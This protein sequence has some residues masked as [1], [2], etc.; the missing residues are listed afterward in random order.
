MAFDYDYGYGL[1]GCV[2]FKKSAGWEKLKW[3]GPR[4]RRRNFPLKF[5]VW[6]KNC[7]RHVRTVKLK[8]REGPW[9][10][11]LSQEDIADA[12]DDQDLQVG[13]L[14]E[15]LNDAPLLQKVTVH[16]KMPVR[17]NKQT[18]QNHIA[19][20]REIKFG[21][22]LLGLL[23]SL[24]KGEIEFKFEVY[25]FAM[26]QAPCFVSSFITKVVGSLARL[27]PCYCSGTISVVVIPIANQ[28][29]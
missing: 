22:R 7:L 12:Y 21:K 10:S 5:S 14:V 3:Y 15:H 29:D 26:P 25:D 16:V 19:T 8:I 13:R 18:F 11:P 4:D 2:P 28:F 1:E 6:L 27:L 17:F 23:Q 20:E 9:D 24:K